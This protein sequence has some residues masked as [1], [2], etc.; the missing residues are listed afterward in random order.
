MCRIRALRIVGLLVASIVAVGVVLF[1]LT[2]PEYTDDEIRQSFVDTWE[3]SA[4]VTLALLCVLAFFV[5]LALVVGLFSKRS[6]ERLLAAAAL[7]LTLGAATLAYW[8]HANLTD[9]TAALTGQEFGPCHGLCG[10]WSN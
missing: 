10:M 3:P 1:T 6:A 2:T 7:L 5:L 9:R 4:I 8:T